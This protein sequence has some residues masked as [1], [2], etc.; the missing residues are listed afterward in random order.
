MR[1]VEYLKGL[2]VVLGILSIMRSRGE[3]LTLKRLR[4]SMSGKNLVAKEDSGFCHYGVL[5]LLRSR[6]KNIYEI[7][8]L[9]TRHAL[10]LVRRRHSVICCSA[11]QSLAGFEIPALIVGH[12]RAVV[13]KAGKLEC[14][15]Q[16][17]LMS[18]PEVCV[19]R[20]AIVVWEGFP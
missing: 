11:K 10:L 15:P 16:I 6:Y 5:H 14:F 19:L 18:S 4:C 17:Q 7:G 8:K 20:A 9:M 1:Y 13:H 2:C 3:I 12:A